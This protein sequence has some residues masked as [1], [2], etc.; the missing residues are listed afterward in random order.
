MDANTPLQTLHLA[1][2]WVCSAHFSQD[3]YCQPKKTSNPET[4]LPQENGCPTSRE[5]Y[6][7]S[8]AKLVTSHSPEVRERLS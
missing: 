5:S 7:H 4:P 6:R 3:D 8:G 1:D 2:H